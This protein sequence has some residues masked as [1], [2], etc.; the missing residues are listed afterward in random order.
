MSMSMTIVLHRMCASAGTSHEKCCVQRF[1]RGNLYC[2]RGLLE[3]YPN[4]GR[5]KET[6]L[7]GALDT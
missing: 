5:G 2:V 3:K 4:F 1:H 7:P 6:G